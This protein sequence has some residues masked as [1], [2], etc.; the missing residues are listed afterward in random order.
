MSR[1][2]EPTYGRV[3]RPTY[4]GSENKPSDKEAEG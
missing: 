2:D 3:D 1:K 4:A